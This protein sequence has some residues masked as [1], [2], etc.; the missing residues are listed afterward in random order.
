M[1]SPMLARNLRVAWKPSPRPKFSGMD[2]TC[3]GIRDPGV[4][5]SNHELAP[6]VGGPV[7]YAKALRLTR[8][9]RNQRVHSRIVIIDRPGRYRV[10]WA[11]IASTRI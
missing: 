1:P 9:R 8:L 6:F 5:R 11:W 10:P 4:C 7:S 2:T 3:V